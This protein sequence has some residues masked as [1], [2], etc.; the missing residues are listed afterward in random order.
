MAICWYVGIA[1]NISSCAM[2]RGILVGCIMAPAGGPMLSLPVVG[3]PMACGVPAAAAM[4]VATAMGPDV[5]GGP[6]LANVDVL[7]CWA[8]VSC[9]NSDWLESNSNDRAGSLTATVV[10]SWPIFSRLRSRSSA[11]RKR[12]SCGTLYQ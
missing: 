5:G 11:S 7:V 9:S 1:V 12:R 8:L 2:A 10:A 3:G 4:L 6:E